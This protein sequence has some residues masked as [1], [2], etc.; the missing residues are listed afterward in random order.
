VVLLLNC[1]ATLF[2]TGVI[3]FVQLVHYPLFA[4]VGEAGFSA[5][6]ARHA[7]LTTLVVMPPM[8]IEL[9]TAALLLVRRPGIVSP[10]E[11]WSGL[12]LV[13]LIWVSTAVLQV[14]LHNTLGSGFDATAHQSLVYGNWLR[15]VAWSLRSLL[16]GLWLF[17]LIT[18]TQLSPHP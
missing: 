3:W 4:S 16:V 18:M 14:P 12:V 15:T 13:V 5:Y 2:M 6:E 11:A 8:V 10:P 9:L 7:S 1:L 17:R